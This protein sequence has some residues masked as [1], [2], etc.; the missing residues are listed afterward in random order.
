MHCAFKKFRKSQKKC[1]KLKVDLYEIGIVTR[2]KHVILENDT[3]QSMI[4][5]G[6]WL[7]FQ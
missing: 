6:G 3:E 5:D 2:G 1:K 7:H 4:I